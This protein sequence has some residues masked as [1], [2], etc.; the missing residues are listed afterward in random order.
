[1]T[2]A[3]QEGEKFHFVYVIFFPFYAFSIIPFLCHITLISLLLLRLSTMNAMT[4][5]KLGDRKFHPP[6]LFKK[7]DTL[8]SVKKRVR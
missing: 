2:V 8:L 1:M 3:S 4:I 7:K 6:F 5:R